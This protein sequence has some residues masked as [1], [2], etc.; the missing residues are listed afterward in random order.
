MVSGTGTKSRSS[1]AIPAMVRFTA[2]PVMCTPSGAHARDSLVAR[3]VR[4]LPEF[5]ADRKIEP[6][7]RARQR[8]TCFDRLRACALGGGHPT[9]RLLWR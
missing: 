6:P 7:K 2:T 1:A 5:D 8:S 3:F 9:H 4:A